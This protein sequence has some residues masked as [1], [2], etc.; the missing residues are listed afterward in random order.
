MRKSTL[1]ILFAII[2]LIA[3]GAIYAYKEYNRTVKDIAGIVPAFTLTSDALVNDFTK[4][5]SIANIN[6]LGKTIALSGKVKAIEKDESGFFTVILGDTAT[7]TSIRCSMDSAYNNDAIALKEGAQ[8]NVKGIC[9]GYN[10]D[11]M[12]LGADIILNRSY[13]IKQ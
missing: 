1:Y 6:Y 13:I 9:T 4:N 12:G 11:E 7:S 3:G 10:K 2:L 5:D 8:I